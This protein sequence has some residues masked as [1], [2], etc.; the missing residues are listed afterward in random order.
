MLPSA[1]Y[2]IYFPRPC[3]VIDMTSF[4]QITTYSSQQIVVNIYK[5]STQF[6]TTSLSG[7]SHT[8]SRI[9]TSPTSFS[10]SDYMVI[11]T[12]TTDFSANDSV[13]FN[14]AVSYL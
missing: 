8:M 3:N 10:L 14:C 13:F 1:P 11:E 7:T 6:M 12:V 4:S 2:F 5:N 9:D